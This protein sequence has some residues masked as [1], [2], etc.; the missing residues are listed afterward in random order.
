MK[1]SIEVSLPSTPVATRSAAQVAIGLWFQPCASVSE[2]PLSRATASSARASASVTVI[3]FSTSTCAPA[4]RAASAWAR[5]HGFGEATT[6]PSQPAV[7]QVVDLLAGDREPEGA[8]ERVE[9][10][11]APAHDADQLDVLLRGEERQV[12]LGRPVA[13]ADDPD[14]GAGAHATASAV[15]AGSAATAPARPR[16][17]APRPSGANG[18][19]WS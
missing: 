18:A 6:I 5:C 16:P 10:V 19:G 4:R 14:A 8:L 13:G 9:R 11:A 1:R 3:G 2:R 12:E 7:E 15:A 17:A